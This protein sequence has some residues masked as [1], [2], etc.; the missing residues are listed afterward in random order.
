MVPRFRF[1]SVAYAIQA[2]TVASGG[3]I[4]CSQLTVSSN[5]LNSGTF[6]SDNLSSSTY[7]L[8]SQFSGAGTADVKAVYGRSVAAPFWGYGGY[9]QG[10]FI[11]AFGI[12]DTTGT[13]SRYGLYGVGS[14]GTGGSFGVYGSATSVT[15]ASGYGVYGFAGGAGTN[16]AGYF[17]GNVNVTGT[18]SKGGGSFKIDDP[19]DPANKYLYHSFVESPDMKNVYDG[20]VILDPDGGTTIQLPAWFDVLN[21]DFRYQLTA[22][23]APAP[24]L[25]VAQEVVNNTFRIAGGSPGMKVSWQVTG[26]RKDP[27]ANA[28]RI[29]VEVEKP[30]SERGKYLYPVEQGLPES[31]GVDYQSAHPDKKGNQ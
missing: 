28:H 2:G 13:G 6:L 22:I 29:P 24:G 17:A 7:I 20:V 4:T 9:F 1:T 3:A 8:Y 10:G 18:L 26:I 23:G 21:R 31:M 11:G 5:G 15:G 14:N 25:Y 12:A 30:P 16:Y 19:I 27:F